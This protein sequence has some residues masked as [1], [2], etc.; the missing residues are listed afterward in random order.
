MS[1]RIEVTVTATPAAI[2]DVLDRLA[3]AL[4][5]VLDSIQRLRERVE[6]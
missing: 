2:G 3:V 6:Q 1:D 4:T 5:D